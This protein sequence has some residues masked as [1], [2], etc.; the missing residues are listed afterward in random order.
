[1]RGVSN[2][3]II[4]RGRGLYTRTVQLPVWSRFF[5]PCTILQ[6]AILIGINIAVSILTD[7]CLTYLVLGLSSLTTLFMCYFAV[8]AVRTENIYQ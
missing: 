1:M 3:Y 5:V 7:D 8:E 6:A 4:R 2:F